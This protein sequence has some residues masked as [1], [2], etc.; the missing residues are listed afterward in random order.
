MK[1]IILFK[2]IIPEIINAKTPKE[3]LKFLAIDDI[4]IKNDEWNNFYE[5][6]SIKNIMNLLNHHQ[7]YNEKICAI[8]ELG[9]FFVLS[10]AE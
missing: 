9:D 4:K 10:D 2:N 3:A 5:N 8:Y 1:Y 6:E 7:S